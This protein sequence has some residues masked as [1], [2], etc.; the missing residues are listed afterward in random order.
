MESADGYL[1]KAS[2][3]MFDLYKNGFIGAD[4]VYAYNAKIIAEIDLRK[5][6]VHKGKTITH[7]IKKARNFVVYSD[8]SIGSDG[9][10][11]KFSI[12]VGRGN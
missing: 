7:R 2:K 9:D 5:N 10:G 11:S 4:E 12:E 8:G 3:C 1:E 6:S